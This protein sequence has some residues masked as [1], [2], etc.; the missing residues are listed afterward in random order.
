MPEVLEPPR[1]V[2]A[3]DLG[4]NS[5][6][7]VI[8]RVVGEELSVLDRLREPVRLAGGLDEHG[9]LAEEAVER[10]LGCLE[11]F[12][13][14]LRDIPRGHVRAVGTNTLRRAGPAGHLLS[15]LRRAL[16]VPIEIL[17]GPEEARLIYLGVAHDLAQEEGRRLVVDIGG[18]STECILGER[19]T[20][21]FTDSLQMGCVSYSMRYFPEGRIT[22]K[23]FE[24]ATIAARLELETIEQRFRGTGW[25]DCV[26][27]SG[28]I[29]AVAGILRQAG[30]TEGDVRPAGLKRLRKALITAGSTGAL[31]LA[32]LSE[33]RV[34]VLPGG[35]A[36]L[37]A[38][39]ESLGIESMRTSKAAL[40]EGLLYDLIGRIRHE[41]VRDRTIRSLSERYS[42]DQAQAARVEAT[43]LALLEQAADGLEVEREAA[44]HVL[45]W[46]AR[47]HEIGLAVAYSG[48]QKHGAYILANTSLPGFSREDQELL[49]ALVRGHRRKLTRELFGTLPPFHRE[50]AFRL[51][52]LL[53]L[54]VRLHRARSPRPLPALG[55]AAAGA[56]LDLAFPPGWL[57]AHPLTRADLEEEAGILA[58]VGIELA[59]A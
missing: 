24:K 36:I 23:A 3:V 17:P 20:A 7:L 6:H 29:L 50:L 18:G 46:A 21:L 47:L 26:G 59:T 14:R 28:T 51:A 9:R 34:P 55:L 44:A 52:L 48:H 39:F 41:D 58:G 37:I 25:R 53:R 27:S 8:G 35:L 30:W 22:R 54:A 33:D 32:D 45:S 2:A 1:S 13:Q 38:V 31:A 43:A 5:F 56:R 40:R 4:S 10:A 42:V 15:R 49:A 12:A 57:D 16:G 19:F 11:R